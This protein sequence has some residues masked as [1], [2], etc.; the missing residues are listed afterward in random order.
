M[1]YWELIDVGEKTSA[2]T[3]SS[4]KTMS[5]NID[6]ILN[7][8]EEMSKKDNSAPFDFDN[9]CLSDDEISDVL[10][11]LIN[12]EK[13]Y[14]KDIP[15]A[16]TLEK[17]FMWNIPKSVYNA[18]NKVTVCGLPDCLNPLYWFYLFCTA[19]PEDMIGKFITTAVNAIPDDD[20]EELVKHADEYDTTYL[21]SDDNDDESVDYYRENQAYTNE[22]F[23]ELNGVDTEELDET[24]NNED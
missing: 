5:E 10:S 11:T 16:E 13:K 18:A 9:T 19:E 21:T 4:Q 8:I 7:Y 15:L 12:F 1:K 23:K 6:K 14:F 22:E 3:L 24:I 20:Y 17:R 2:P